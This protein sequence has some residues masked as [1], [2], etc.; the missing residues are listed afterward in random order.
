MKTSRSSSRP[1]IL[2]AALAAV[3]LALFAATATAKT[4]ARFKV[5]LKATSTMVWSEDITSSCQGSGQLRTISNGETVVT[6]RSRK[7]PVVSLEHAGD[8]TALVFTGGATGLP[9]KGTVARKVEEE[10]FTVV[11][12]KPGACGTPEPTPR[13]CGTRAYPSDSQI[14]L[15]YLTFGEWPFETTP[16]LK[17]VLTISG[18]NSAQWTAGPPFRNCKS[19]ARGDLLSGQAGT[20]ETPPLTFPISIAALL[21][22]RHFTL[23]ANDSLHFDALKYVTGVSGSRPVRI[24]TTVS[25]S[26][27]RVG[28]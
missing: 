4:L 28:R 17:D 24:E 15:T 3:L 6:V 9:V 18:P 21:A 10:G 1:F 13:D 12:P 16:P 27:T 7:Q 19:P 11:A 25:L 8:S 2:A 22:R 26:F 23:K 5:G 14:G 20:Y